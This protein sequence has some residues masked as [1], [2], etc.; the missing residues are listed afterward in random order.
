[1]VGRCCADADSAA[2]ASAAAATAAIKILPVV[3]MTFPPLGPEPPR[4][5][6]LE[7]YPIKWD[8]IWF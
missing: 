7:P 4:S 2:P 6:V 3:L 5:R 1:M 8:R